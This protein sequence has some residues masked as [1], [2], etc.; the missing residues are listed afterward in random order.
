M[1]ELIDEIGSILRS[2]CKELD[3]NIEFFD[4]CCD[5]TSEIV[6]FDFSCFYTSL[7]GKEYDLVA[8]FVV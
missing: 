5:F 4:D 3:G 2:C 7:I 8:I 6:F 1:E